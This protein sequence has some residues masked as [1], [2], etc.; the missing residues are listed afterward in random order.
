MNLPSQQFSSGDAYLS[1]RNQ[2]D[3][4]K[5]TNELHQL[6]PDFARNDFPLGPYRNVEPLYN[7]LFVQTSISSD[8]V[9]PTYD[10]ALLLPS[11]EEYLQ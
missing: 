7:Y 5:Y 2:H 10:E 11:L 4:L 3:T 6:N 9:T 1:G 8:H